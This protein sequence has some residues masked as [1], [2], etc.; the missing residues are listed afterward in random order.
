MRLLCSGNM[1]MPP[2]LLPRVKACCKAVVSLIEQSVQLQFLQ[3]LAG[4]VHARMGKSDER[5]LWFGVESRVKP[6][7]HGRR[8]IYSVSVDRKGGE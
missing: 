7:C 1:Q 5:S 3:R 4:L 6:R 8:S 2:P